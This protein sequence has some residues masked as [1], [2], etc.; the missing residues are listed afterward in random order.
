MIY[1]C[2][3]GRRFIHS[4]MTSSRTT[5]HQLAGNLWPIVTL[6]WVAT[7]LFLRARDG[8]GGAVCRCATRAGRNRVVDTAP[9]DGNWTDVTAW[10]PAPPVAGDTVVLPDLGTSYTV[11]SSVASV[12]LA[13][14]TLASPARLNITA[15]TFNTGAVSNF[16]N[17]GSITYNGATLQLGFIGSGTGPIANIRNIHGPTGTLR[18]GLQGTFGGSDEFDISGLGTVHTSFVTDVIIKNSGGNGAGSLV[19]ANGARLRA[20]CSRPTATAPVR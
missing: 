4:R 18:T 2:G 6:V 3:L 7:C 8:G 17:D 16:H 11:T 19:F 1:S 10:S 15:G 12:S 5:R 9:G 14:L 13:G 20:R